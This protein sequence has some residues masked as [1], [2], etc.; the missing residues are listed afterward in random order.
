M[1]H[2]GPVAGSQVPTA[3]QAEQD[4]T[5]KSSTL[6]NAFW[7]VKISFLGSLEENQV[8]FREIMKKSKDTLS[9][10]PLEPLTY[11]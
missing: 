6:W 3:T 8:F 7:T 10:T 9:A 2:L 11:I 1:Q 4:N 5:Q